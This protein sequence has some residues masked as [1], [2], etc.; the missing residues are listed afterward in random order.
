MMSDFRIKRFGG[1]LQTAF[2]A[3]EE[4]LAPLP[5]AWRCDLS[6][7]ALSWAPG[8]FDMFGIPPGT[9]VERPEALEMYTDESR[10]LLERLRADAIATCSAF[11]FEAQIRRPDGVPR[12]LRITADVETKGGRA[13][14]LYGMKQDITPDPGEDFLRLLD[15]I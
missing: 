10:E 7:D 9:R 6:N 13:T 12:W 5:A 11:T 1:A 4:R 3:M 8:V 14:H 15:R 2:P